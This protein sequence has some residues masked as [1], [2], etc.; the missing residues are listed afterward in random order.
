MLKKPS[1]FRNFEN[2]ETRAAYAEI[3]ASTQTYETKFSKL[4]N[5]F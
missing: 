2:K 5:H 3:D 4:M 1:I